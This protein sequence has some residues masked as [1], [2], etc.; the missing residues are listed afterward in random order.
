MNITEKTKVYF[1]DGNGISHNLRETVEYIRR[2]LNRHPKF[3][4][5]DIIVYL[6]EDSGSPMVKLIA[7]NLSG[8]YKLQNRNG[9][10]A[11][12]VSPNTLLQTLKDGFE[13]V[14]VPIAG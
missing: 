14:F 5:T 11:L 6:H 8:V 13:P 12:F 2:N 9:E 3:S 7:Q 4:A 1:R 10:S